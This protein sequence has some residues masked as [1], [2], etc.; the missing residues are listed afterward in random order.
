MRRKKKDYLKYLILF[1]IFTVLCA[2]VY[3]YYWQNIQADYYDAHEAIWENDQLKVAEE[4][5]KF[6]SLIVSST[7]LLD[8]KAQQQKYKTHLG[9]L[10]YHQ[11]DNGPR[12]L[13][14]SSNSL[15]AQ[16]KYL[17]E[18]GYQFKQLSDV[19]DSAAS[20]TVKY[21]KTIVLTFDDGYRSFYTAAYPILKKYNI[22]ATLFVINQDIGKR[23]YVTWEMMKEMQAS[24]LVEIGAHT[25]NHKHLDKLKLEKVKCQIEESKRQLEVGLKTQIKVF[26]YPYG[27]YNQKIEEIVKQAGFIGAVGV[28]NGDRPNAEGLFAWRRIM[29]TNA[30]QGVGLLRK[31]F[32]AFEVVK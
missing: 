29:I 14:V 10:M 22:P 31:V 20:G 19:F 3:F 13:H 24:G 30:E 15:D 25:M 16:I 2:G 32:V 1:L 11:I 28:Y 26:A 18:Q 9:L 4:E 6:I 8:K 7:P 23:G 5:N 21:D 12:R 27:G 17:L